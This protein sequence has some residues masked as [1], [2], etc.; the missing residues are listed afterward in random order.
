MD[1]LLTNDDGIDSPGIRALS[2]ALSAVGDVL[3]V[4]PAADQ[5][6]IGRAMSDAVTVEERELGYAVDGTPA[7]CVVAGLE[8]IGPH[9]DLVVA[10]CNR[11]ANL[12]AYS[13]GRSGTVSA[14]VEGASFGI[15]SLAVSLYIPGPFE[16]NRPGIEAYDEAARVTTFLADRAVAAGVF[17]DAEYLNVNVPPTGGDRAPMAITRPSLTYDMTAVRRDDG[18]ITLRD[19]IWE[20]MRAG[21]L[22][23]PRGTD[24]HAV[25]DGRTS[26][27][28]LTAPHTADDHPVLDTLV[29]E[30]NA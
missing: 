12:G 3:V 29:A 16:G 6:A 27:S 18:T 25:I 7:D 11:G 28:P 15:P 5:S 17:E 14:A 8:A 23:E 20:H 2:D 26:I 13:I 19:R 30:Y 10:G 21:D 24:R 9:P 4:A 1:I 22:D